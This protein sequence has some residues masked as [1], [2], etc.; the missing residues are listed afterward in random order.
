MRKMAPRTGSS[1]ENATAQPEN[2]GTF[3]AAPSHSGSAAKQSSQHQR[4]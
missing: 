2:P 1:Y 3:S 4:G